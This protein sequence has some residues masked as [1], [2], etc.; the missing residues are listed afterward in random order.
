MLNTINVSRMAANFSLRGC[1]WLAARASSGAGLPSACPTLPVAALTGNLVEDINGVVVLDTDNHGL[2]NID[3]P[4]IG[5]AKT[6]NIARLRQQS[7]TQRN[8][9]IACYHSEND[10]L[11]HPHFVGAFHRCTLL[12]FTAANEMILEGAANLTNGTGD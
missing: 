12:S 9:K 5:D 1:P 4:A 6:D 3:V 2:E 10:R 8:A 11:P 7:T